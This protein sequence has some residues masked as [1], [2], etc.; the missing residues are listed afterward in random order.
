MNNGWFVVGQFLKSKEVYLVVSG[1][2]VWEVLLSYNY[3]PQDISLKGSVC[4][5]ITQ[6]QLF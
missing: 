5:C 6:N 4:V 3:Q 1:L 2:D